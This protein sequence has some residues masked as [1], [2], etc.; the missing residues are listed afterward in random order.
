MLVVVHSSQAQPEVIEA[1]KSTNKHYNNLFLCFSRAKG[2]KIYAHAP[3]QQRQSFSLMVK[4]PNYQVTVS[5]A[6]YQKACLL[7]WSI[8]HR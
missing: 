7:S 5:V 1:T 4:S 8:S 3:S 6:E 2:T